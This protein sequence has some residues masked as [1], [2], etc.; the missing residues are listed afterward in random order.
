MK[1]YFINTGYFSGTS[2]YSE[3]TLRELRETPESCIIHMYDGRIITNGRILIGVNFS[4]V[5]KQVTLTYIYTH[6]I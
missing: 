4:E 3:N 1:K 2:F 5:P 6:T